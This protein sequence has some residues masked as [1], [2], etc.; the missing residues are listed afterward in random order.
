MTKNGEQ[1]RSEDVCLAVGKHRKMSFCPSFH[2]LFD[3][4]ALQM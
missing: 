2:V 3:A 4:S 1:F